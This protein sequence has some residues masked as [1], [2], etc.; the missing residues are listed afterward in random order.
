MVMLGS[1]Q[2]HCAL[3]A[4]D[5]RRNTAEPLAIEAP[6]KGRKEKK[7]YSARKMEQRACSHIVHVKMKAQLMAQGAETP[8]PRQLKQPFISSELSFPAVV[9]ITACKG[10]YSQ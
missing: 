7:P 5:C 4:E 10:L 9:G 3:P 8:P 1:R 6:G 2:Q